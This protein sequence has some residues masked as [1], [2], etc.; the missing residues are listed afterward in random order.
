M[1]NFLF[2][3][4]EN[5]KFIIYF[6][7]LL[8][9]SSSDWSTNSQPNKI[10]QTK[11]DLQMAFEEFFKRNSSNDPNGSC[12]IFNFQLSN[13]VFEIFGVNGML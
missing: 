4:Y 13:Q 9:C 11:M 6:S 3:R 7:Y 8:N 5:G 12:K 1:V 2:C 10:D